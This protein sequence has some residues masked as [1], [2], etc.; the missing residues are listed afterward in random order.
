[1]RLP[2]T[3]AT[4]QTRHKRKRGFRSARG[5]VAMVALW[6]FSIGSLTLSILSSHIFHN[7]LV[8]IGIGAAIGGATSNL[9]DGLRRGAVI[10]FIDVGFW[11]IFNLA[12]IAIV[13]GIALALLNLH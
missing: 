3:L 13:F 12:D 4:V 2:W 10:D 5:R 6:A 7:Q 11:P 1:M 8:R 9:L